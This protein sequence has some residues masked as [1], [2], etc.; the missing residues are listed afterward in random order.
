MH[1]GTPSSG[2][3][4]QWELACLLQTPLMPLLRAEQIPAD[5]QH[6]FAVQDQQHL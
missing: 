1:A 6:T 5:W 4:R 3:G 2:V